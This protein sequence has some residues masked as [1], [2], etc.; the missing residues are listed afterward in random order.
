MEAT[1]L[2]GERSLAVAATTAS[3]RSMVRTCLGGPLS[4][5]G[6]PAALAVSRCSPTSSC[7]GPGKGARLQSRFAGRLSSRAKVQGR[8]ARGPFRRPTHLSLRLAARRRARHMNTDASLID[9]CHLLARRVE[10]APPGKARIAVT[11]PTPAVTV[12]IAQLLEGLA[13]TVIQHAQPVGGAEAVTL[14]V[15]VPDDTRQQVIDRLT[16]SNPAT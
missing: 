4:L 10:A 14:C 11:A 7:I 5:R 2:L 12:A 15:G 8:D 3:D 16:R 13:K 6:C 9:T 1:H